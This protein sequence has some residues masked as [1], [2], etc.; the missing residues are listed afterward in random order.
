MT[1]IDD[2]FWW[3]WCFLGSAGFFIAATLLQLVR[4]ISAT[5]DAIALRVYGA[6]TR[7]WLAQ[8]LMLTVAYFLTVAVLRLGWGLL[9]EASTAED[10]E[11]LVLLVGLV[12]A[13]HVWLDWTVMVLFGR[14][15]PYVALALRANLAST[16][17][18]MFF[19]VFSAL[20][21]SVVSLLAWGNSQRRA[22][23]YNQCIS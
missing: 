23:G 13:V 16:A 2:E 18:V 22:G 5:A 20:I 15:R 17:L 19:S 6:L 8:G 1:L 12:P 7:S 14:R 4:L 11:I 9:K 3:L 10:G 21:Y